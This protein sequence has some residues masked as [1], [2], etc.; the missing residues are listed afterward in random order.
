MLDR[1]VAMIRSSE[2]AVY[3]VGMDNG[4]VWFEV[5]ISLGR[6]QPAALMSSVKPSELPDILRSPWLRPYETDAE[7]IQGALG[8]LALANVPPIVAPSRA[9]ADPRK[10]I[11]VGDGD[12][13]TTVAHRLQ[14][15]AR[16]TE[17]VS[18]AGIRSVLD[19]IDLAESGGMIV[20]VRPP[21]ERWDGHAAIASLLTLG[22]GFGLQRNVVLAAGTGEFVPSDCM[23]LIVRGADNKE[24]ADAVLAALDRP[25]P[26]APLP[27]TT[28]PRIVGALERSQAA[29]V[30]SAIRE[31]RAILLEAE[32]GYG[33]TTLLSQI[34]DRLGWPTGWVT[35]DD[36][37]SGSDLV[38]RL[39]AAVGEHAPGFGWN[40]VVSARTTAREGLKEFRLPS[41]EMLGELLADAADQAGAIDKVLLVVDDVQ[42]ATQ[43]GGRLLGRL[44]Q[45]APAWLYVAIAGR[46]S[47]DPIT[48]M[49][50]GGRLPTWR[51]ED[52]RFSS[53][54]T[55][56]FLRENGR[57]ADDERVSLLHVRTE[58][59]Q[60]ALSVVRVWL[61][62][63]PDA[64]NERLREMARGDRHEVYRIFAT[65]YFAELPQDL[66]DGLLA[67]AL[68]I[69]LDA[70]VA[71]RLYGD[72]GGLRL[73]Q[74]AEGPY[75]ITE[76]SAGLFR[77]HS[78]FREFLS[79]R[80]IDERGRESL[81]AQRSELAR[82]YQEHGDS[83]NAFQVACE[84]EDW[85]TATSSIEPIIRLLAN[86]GD[87]YFVLDVIG[88]LPE[89]RIRQSRHL[90]ESWV[91][92]LSHLG[93]ERARSEAEALASSKTSDESDQALADLLL[94]EL[95][96][97]RSELS[98][99][100]AAARCDEIAERLSSTDK[101]M[102][103]QARLLALGARTARNANPDEWPPLLGAA[104]QAAELA[105]SAEMPAA[106]A[107]ALSHAGDMAGRIFQMAASE[108]RSQLQFLQRLGY[109][110]RPEALARQVERL[111]KIG[112]QAA[113]L[114][115]EAFRL[116]DQT[117]DSVVLAY[118]QYSY[119]RY[120][121]FQA[122]NMVFTAGAI[123]ESVRSLTQDAIR[124]SL[125]A[126]EAYL[127]RGVLR[128]VSVCLNAAAEAAKVQNDRDRMDQYLSKSVELA[129]EHGYRDLVEAAGRIR[130]H[131]TPM[132][133]YDA[134]IHPEPLHRISADDRERLIGALLTQASVFGGNPAKL[135][136]AL[137][138]ELSVLATVDA[139]R[140]VTC[141]YLIGLQ[142]KTGPKVGPFNTEPPTWRVA[143]RIRG[144][145]GTNE[146]KNV[147]ALLRRFKSAHCADC[148]LKS[149]G[150]PERE[151]DEE[152][153]FQPMLD[154]IRQ[155]EAH[156]PA[157]P[158]QGISC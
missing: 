13:A 46:D 60:A 82:W 21:T 8:F 121:T 42:K 97:E 144:I 145:I 129:S 100:E 124:I 125:Q 17:L 126:A 32:P 5:G 18:P 11:V 76:D 29:D 101:R 109:G 54:E 157:T 98:D 154:R 84:A 47:P 128:S 122:L 119:A 102:A 123:T 58:G 75:F 40:A 23:Q 48:R 65:D 72:G 38:D 105:R 155:E 56:T 26:P 52:L 140:E 115:K 22:A 63:H 110:V 59:W 111:V 43:E 24:L 27:G 114:Y 113:E 9:V 88:R 152:R 62:K 117:Q 146:H 68:P 142:N 99:Q 130:A 61:D 4:N 33:K 148:S 7:C 138:E 104:R 37:W 15:P 1:I 107:I 147:G 36:G 74:L 85:E 77:L 89:D 136:N 86:Q 20:C 6:R 108:E 96:Y 31:S 103:V 64:T 87:A 39:V 19:A 34:V 118:V 158:D 14:G 66:R 132:E 28:V 69:R 49:S 91:R 151:I 73:R 112:S 134:A 44:L 51:A 79:Q 71:R 90:W 116:A 25:R 70:E 35:V 30:A 135:R 150:T 131:P 41:P 133:S 57:K 83:A 80:W 2:R 94:V 81:L 67:A 149:P 45:V 12:R 53:G 50:A 78:L 137:E 156:D 3:E 16:T 120:L 106:A 55:S 92:A 141:Q 95:R 139:E 127:R 93:D 10:I 143:C 153:I